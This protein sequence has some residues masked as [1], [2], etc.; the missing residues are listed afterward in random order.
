MRIAVITDDSKTI[1]AHFG[2]AKYYEVFTI[3]ENRVVEKETRPKANHRQFGK[4][5]HDHTRES[6]HG[7]DPAA[8]N[9]HQKMMENISDCQVVI[10]RGMGMGIH[11]SLS[12]SGIRPIL[13]NVEDI[14]SALDAFLAGTLVDHPEKLH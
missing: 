11:Q 1:S 8:Q 2:R 14:G 9:R 3:M 10:A 13:T 12:A 6:A 7:T 5:E 4:E